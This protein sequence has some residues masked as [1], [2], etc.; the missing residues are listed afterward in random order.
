MGRLVEIHHP[1]L[2]LTLTITITLILMMPNS[3]PSMGDSTVHSVSVVAVISE[4]QGENHF[5]LNYI[6]IVQCDRA[7]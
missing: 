5:S 6:P 3:K 1:P 4:R 7:Q 2:T